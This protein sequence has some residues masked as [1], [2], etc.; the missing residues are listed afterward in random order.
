[1]HLRAPK[2]LGGGSDKRRLLRAKKRLEVD[3]SGFPTF[4]AVLAK[5][6][7]LSRQSGGAE[8]GDVKFL[9]GTSSRPSWGV[10]HMTGGHRTEMRRP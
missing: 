7:L 6:M 8:S 2:Q 10:N 5:K 1:M 3:P 9:G 4:N